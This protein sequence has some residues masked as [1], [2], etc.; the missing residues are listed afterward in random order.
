MATNDHLDEMDQFFE[1]SDVPQLIQ[2]ETECTGLLSVKEVESIISKWGKHSA[3]WL[4]PLHS[5][6][7][8]PDFES[9]VCFGF[10]LPANGDPR[11]QQVMAQALGGDPE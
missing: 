9:G 11:R 7:E 4:R 10:Q 3:Q 5:L 6:S 1:R 8:C 2:G